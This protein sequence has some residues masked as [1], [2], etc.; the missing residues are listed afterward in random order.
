[1]LPESTGSNFLQPRFKPANEALKDSSLTEI[2]YLPLASYCGINF[3]LQSILFVVDTFQ[4]DPS[5][6]YETYSL[7][8]D[9]AEGGHRTEHVYSG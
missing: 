8:P 6:F 3:N 1:M 7:I 4:K 5:I 2:T 9:V